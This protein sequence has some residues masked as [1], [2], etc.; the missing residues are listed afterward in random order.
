MIYMFT[1]YFGDKTIVFTSAPPADT[2]DGAICVENGVP[3]ITKMIEK[4]ENNK[5]LFVISHHPEA[6]F[7]EFLTGFKVVEA[8]GG[9]VRNGQGDTLMIYRNDRWDLPKGHLEKKEC[10]EECAVREVEEETGI[11]DLKRGGLVTITY[12]FYYLRDRW[13]MKRTYWYAMLSTGGECVPQEEEGITRAEWVPEAEVRE[14]AAGSFPSIRRVF[15]EA[16]M[17]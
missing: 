2:E 3:T 11:N 17:I 4:L 13:V 9:L 7:N 15:E 8:A 1:V 6:S 14:Y 16:R 10:I 12:H 5:K